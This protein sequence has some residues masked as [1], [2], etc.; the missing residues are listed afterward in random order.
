[1]SECEHVFEIVEDTP[2]DGGIYMVAVCEKCRKGAEGLI[3]FSRFKRE[4][5][6]EQALAAPPAPHKET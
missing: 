2:L 1:M 5:K 4:R 6:N 3:T